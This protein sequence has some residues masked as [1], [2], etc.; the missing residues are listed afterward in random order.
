M[1]GI[2]NWIVQINLNLNC[3]T[4]IDRVIKMLSQGQNFSVI[5]NN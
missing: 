1:K 4:N 2:D 3:S 5:N